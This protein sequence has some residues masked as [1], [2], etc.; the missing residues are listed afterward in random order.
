MTEALDDVRLRV[1][2]NDPATS[3]IAAER[4]LRF[5]GTHKERIV[6]A[7]VFG[8]RTAAEIGAATGLTVVQVDRRT[9]ELQR[10]GVIEVVQDS[11]GNDITRNNYRVWQ[12][13]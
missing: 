13:A 6:S 9:V 7:L 4:A 1:R 10:Q 5:A 2:A 11:A 8:P 3:V 12:I